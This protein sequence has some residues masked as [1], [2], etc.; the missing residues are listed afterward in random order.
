VKR[1]PCGR[2]I[3][4][5]ANQACTYE[6][7]AGK[8]MCHWHWLMRQPANTQQ[9]AAQHRLRAYE[10]V[11]GT[12]A[13]RARVSA[14][15]WPEGERWCAG[16]QSFVPLFY[17]TGSRCKSCASTAAHAG[18]IE[19]AYGISREDYD[20]LLELQDGRCY[21]CRRK[22]QAKRLAVDHDHRTGIVRGLLC[23][24]NENGCNRGVVANLEAAADGG[25]AAA[26]RAVEYLEHP[27][28]ERLRGNPKRITSVVKPE[29]VVQLPPP[30]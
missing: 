5:T 4:G 30:F 22:P 23:A 11:N 20:A 19:R 6:R 13:R 3:V 27:P 26:R 15:E 28:Y 21:I 10:T 14:S 1:R 12:G 8:Q 25:L 17:T 24:N 2:W 9:G 18:A 29:R 7:M 16:C